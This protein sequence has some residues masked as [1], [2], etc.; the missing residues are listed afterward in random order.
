M[1]ALAE[2]WQLHATMIAQNRPALQEETCSDAAAL[3]PHPQ[4][5]LGRL[6]SRRAGA[7]RTPVYSMF[8]CA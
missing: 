7:W 8:T 1:Y 3:R 4:A 2:G 6:A 5:V